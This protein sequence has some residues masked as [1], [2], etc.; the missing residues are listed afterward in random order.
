MD[1]LYISEYIGAEIQPNSKANR[2]EACSLV[3]FELGVNISPSLWIEVRLRVV[4]LWANIARAVCFLHLFAKGTA[5][6]KNHLPLDLGASTA[7]R[8]RCRHV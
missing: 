7:C 2:H 1:R 6:L 5:R 3:L 8:P 4:Y